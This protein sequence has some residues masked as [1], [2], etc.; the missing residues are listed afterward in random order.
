MDVF[1]TA[2]STP[3]LRDA[4]VAAAHELGLFAVLERPRALAELGTKLRIDER[5]LRALV[6]VLVCFGALARA[7]DQLCVAGDRPP[8]PPPPP[9]RRG[10]GRIADVLRSGRP[11]DE[12]DDPVRFHRHLCEAGA[13]AAG[14]L[15]RRFAPL[16]QD[17]SLLDAGGGAGT[18]A[19]AFLAANAQARA[20]LIDRASVIELARP[21][22]ARFGERAHCVA[23]DLLDGRTPYG[24]EHALALMANLLH[25][26]SPRACLQLV[27][28]AAASVRNNGL[29]VVK[30]I[31]VDADRSGPPSGLLF[32]LNMALYTE[33]GDTY[34]PERIAGWLGAAGLI[35]ARIERLASAPDAVVVWARRP[36]HR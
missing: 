34:D 24:E 15:A 29:V 16:V 21:T 20:R 2:A 9:P 28:R 8:S 3:F 18:Y 22:L 11:L 33:G 1:S 6:D 17:G 36:P 32:A 12:D 26:H 19:A 5:R 30:E 23:G 14:E 7:G 25:L 13:A 10:W 27:A 4:A 35:D 31:L